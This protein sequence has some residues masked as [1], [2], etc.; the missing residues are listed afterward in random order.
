MILLSNSCT[1]QEF[2]SEIT[3]YIKSINN[4]NSSCHNPWDAGKAVFREKS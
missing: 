4:E 3:E 1:Q 2:Q